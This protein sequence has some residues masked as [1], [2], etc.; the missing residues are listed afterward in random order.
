MVEIRQKEIWFAD[1][2]PSKGSEQS[3]TRPVV[4][5]SGDLLN[6]Y[7][8][9]VW[10]V[11]LTSKIKNYKGNP[12][13]SPNEAN[14]LS[15]KSEALVFHLQSATKDRLLRKVGVIEDNEFQ[16]IKKTIDDIIRL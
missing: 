14:K 12:V 2:N 3:G 13:L 5:V 7:L 16:R 11:P 15:A 6:K 9:V 8:N 4:V 1:L 10:I